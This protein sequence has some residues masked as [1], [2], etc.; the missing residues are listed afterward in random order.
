MILLLL[1]W[2]LLLVDNQPA[3]KIDKESLKNLQGTW[4]LQ[5][6][7]HGGVQSDKQAIA[8]ITLT[9]R[10]GKFVTRENTEIKEEAE[11]EKLD[12]K[13]NPATI[14]LRITSGSDRDKTVR[15]IWKRDGDT[16]I[17]CMAEPNRERPKEFAGKVGSGHT[18][19]RF[20]KA[21]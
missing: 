15:G 6:H 11:I 10:T 3:D 4:Q 13:A 19:L 9:V 7:E 20:T 2:S 1:G 14:D 12:G 8:A 5:L 16:L 17:F 21:K 18:L